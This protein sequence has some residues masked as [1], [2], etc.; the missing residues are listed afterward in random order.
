[1]VI[2]ALGKDLGIGRVKIKLWDGIKSIQSYVSHLLILHKN[3]IP[4]DT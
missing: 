3:F 1:M 2:Y 4:W